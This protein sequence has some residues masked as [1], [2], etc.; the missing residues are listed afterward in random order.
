MKQMVAKINN[1]KK[2]KHPVD[3]AAILHKEFVFIN[4]FIN[5]NGRV[6]RLLMNLVL[7]QKGYNIAIIPKIL[8]GEYIECLK[9]AHVDEKDFIYFIARMVKESQKDYL[10][11]FCK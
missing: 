5:E 8:R 1:M 6:A 2:E 11:L 9:K 10:R 7:L 4:P 3:L